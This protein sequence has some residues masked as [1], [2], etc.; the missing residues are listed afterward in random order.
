MGFDNYTGPPKPI[1]ASGH[2]SFGGGGNPR[3]GRNPHTHRQA[4]GRAAAAFCP[5]SVG[6]V[7]EVWWMAGAAFRKTWKKLNV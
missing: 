7:L 1:V 2:E 5:A 4:T 6:G 3:M